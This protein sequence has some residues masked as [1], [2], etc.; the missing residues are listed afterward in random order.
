MAIRKFEL[1]T[2]LKDDNQL[3]RTGVLRNEH[4]LDTSEEFQEFLQ[5]CRRGDLKRCQE[6]ISAGVNINAKDQFDY[7]PLVIASLCGHFELVQ[8]LLESGALADPDSFERER[9]VYNALNNKIRNLLL[10]YDYSKAADPLQ[11]WSSHITSLLVRDSPPTSDIVLS[12]PTEDFHLH[13]FFLS[14]R[15]PYFMRK[16]TA[17]PK[18]V[19]WKLPHAI[20]VEAFRLVLRY[21]YLGDLPRDLVGPGSDVS[22]EDVFRG[23]D[24]LC[25]KLELEKLWEAVL[26]IN[27]RRLARQ[28]HQDEVR[29]AQAQVEALFRDTVL[30]EKI[31]VDTAEAAD[32]RWPRHNPIFADCVLRADDQAEDESSTADA[33]AAPEERT[34]AV[35]AGGGAAPGNSSAARRRGRSVLFPVHKSFLIRSPYF[36]TM[37]SS[38]FVEAR[39]DQ[40]HLRVVRVD[41]SPAVLEIILLFLYTEKADC[42]LEHALDLLYAADMLLLDKLKTKAAVAISTLGSGSRNALVDRT[43]ESRRHHHH[44]HHHHHN[45]HPPSSAPTPTGQDGAAAAAA[46]E[47]DAEP[48]NIYDVIRAAWDLKVQR[49]E[50]FAARYLAGRLEDYVDEPEFAELIRESAGRIRER[51]ETD[52]IELLDDIR[53][54]L[55][56]RFRLRF[57]ADGLEEMLHDDDGDDVKT[58]GEEE[59][60]GGG[61]NAA[62]DSGGGGGSG[63]RGVRALNG[64]VVEDEFASDAIN[65]Q[66]LMEKIDRMLERLKLDA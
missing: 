24:E 16:F 38:D 43:H 53:Y 9:A 42:P 7:T 33:E 6:L 29:R 49:L 28:R 30:R 47:A 22:E 57:D 40:D 50:E 1:E 58:G 64:Q 13:K 63:P 32:V 34:A 65:Y 20:P 45:H 10:S 52:T 37:F 18:T 48:V 66:I 46:A 35:P 39:D 23:V 62:A 51:H 56:E 25:R 60:G 2:K 54:F 55:S 21:L 61:E 3:I 31:E 41:C 59:G 44:H 27:D 36:E 15:S 8:L 5:A 12:A 26:S 14:A 4:P 17:D 11:P 19:T